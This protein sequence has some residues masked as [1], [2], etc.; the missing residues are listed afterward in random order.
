MLLKVER[1]LQFLSS[2]SS[3]LSHHILPQKWDPESF[4]NAL[5]TVMI[6]L[7]NDQI[8][9]FSLLWSRLQWRI[10]AYRLEFSHDF[11]GWSIFCPVKWNKT[12]NRNKK[13]K[14]ER[15]R[16]L[17]GH[18]TFVLWNQIHYFL[19]L[20]YRGPISLANPKK[21]KRRPLEAIFLW[22]VSKYELY[23]NT[24]TENAFNSYHQS[25]YLETL[26]EAR[27]TSVR[28]RKGDK[29]TESFDFFALRS[30]LTK[31]LWLMQRKMIPMVS[32]CS[33]K[34]LS[35]GSLAL[36]VNFCWSGVLLMGPLSLSI[37]WVIA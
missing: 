16:M 8:F 27:A 19:L 34:P 5:W 14:R 10:L 26:L 22:K 7:Q 18:T 23:W 2:S 24:E 4:Q 17:S 12:T 20:R 6:Q 28:G 15:E 37:T 13:K 11:Q 36:C 25:L 35:S 21:K 29:S 31:S 3:L 33:E 32:I 9:T 1:A 30:T